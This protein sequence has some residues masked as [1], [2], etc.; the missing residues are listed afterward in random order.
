MIKGVPAYGVYFIEGTSA[1]GRSEESDV[2]L[3]DPSVSRNHAEIDV[4]TR[5][6]LVR[7]LGSTNGTFVNGERV[8]GSKRGAR[9]RRVDV[10]KYATASRGS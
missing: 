6:A 10:R 8:D 2:F 9:G 7:D 3:V 1:I 5:G 4:D